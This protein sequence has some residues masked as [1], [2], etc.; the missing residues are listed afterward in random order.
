MQGLL[1]RISCICEVRKHLKFTFKISTLTY[2]FSSKEA[3]IFYILHSLVSKSY[4]SCLPNRL[5]RR[6]RRRRLILIHI[7]QTSRTTI[8]LIIPLA[9]HITRLMIRISLQNRSS[10]KCRIAI[11]FLPI[12][13]TGIDTIR[14]VGL[15]ERRARL[16]C[17]ACTIR[18]RWPSKETPGCSFVVA[19]L[20]NVRVYHLWIGGV[21]VSSVV[22]DADSSAS[23]ASFCGVSR[24]CHCALVVAKSRGTG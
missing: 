6:R 17:H 3:A 16:H 18:V 7:Q 11:T 15:T 14:H 9:Q 12:F 23:S 13:N 2:C 8:L 10:R 5:P 4:K 22:E 20:I 24:T 21:D 1:Q 19:A